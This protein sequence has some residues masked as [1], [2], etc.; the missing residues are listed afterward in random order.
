MASEIRDEHQNDNDPRPPEGASFVYSKLDR[1]GAEV[2]I[3]A[4]YRLFG[5]RL[6]IGGE[7]N[8]ALIQVE[9]GWD[10]Y[11]KDEKADGETLSLFSA[12][13]KV[14]YRAWDWATLEVSYL[15]GLGKESKRAVV[16][17][18]VFTWPR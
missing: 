8:W 15:F 11:A 4:Q 18:L 1:F 10:R 2:A 17:G 3:G 5:N 14:S 9:H 13:P 7:G 16:V 12:G 6:G